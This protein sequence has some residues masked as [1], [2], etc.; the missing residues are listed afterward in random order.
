[1]DEP[2][3]T[4][5]ISEKVN[6]ANLVDAHPILW[7]GRMNGSLKMSLFSSDHYLLLRTNKG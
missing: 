6:H 1:M 7:R 3:L 5:L 4:C 2:A